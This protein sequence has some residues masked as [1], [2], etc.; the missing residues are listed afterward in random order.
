MLLFGRHQNA[1]P[2]A[3]F[4]QKESEPLPW[5]VGCRSQTCRLW[6]RCQ[7]DK[8]HTCCPWVLPLE[9]R[10][11]QDFSLGLWLRALQQSLCDSVF[12]SDTLHLRQQLTHFSLSHREKAKSVLGHITLSACRAQPAL[13]WHDRHQG[14]DLGAT[15]GPG[16]NARTG[17][18][19]PA[20]HGP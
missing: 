4:T 9:G 2:T 7:E 12:P 11:T 5:A 19:R 20:P 14:E 3:S 6:W 13:Q 18:L 10:S 8:F 17:S 1:G 15:Q 16:Y